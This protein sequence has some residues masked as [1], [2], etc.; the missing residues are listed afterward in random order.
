MQGLY[1][2]DPFLGGNLAVQSSL[3]VITNVIRAFSDSA[4]PA[5]CNFASQVNEKHNLYMSAAF[6][7]TQLQPIDIR[8]RSPD[9][10][11]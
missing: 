11:W 3:M 1:F 6:S 8:A 5:A 9:G 10:R 2:I 7:L 4:Q